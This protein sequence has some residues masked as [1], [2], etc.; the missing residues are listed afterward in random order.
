MSRF[1]RTFKARK[2]FLDELEVGSSV[3]FAARAAGGTT[4]NFKRWRKD[5]EDFARDWDEAEEAGT[6]HLEDEA[7]ARAIKKSDPLMMFMLKARRPEKFDRG[8]K[9]ELSGGIDVTGAKAKL[10]NKI[11]R[12][13]AEGKLPTGGNKEEPEILEAAPQEKQK[14]LPPPDPSVSGKRGSKRR[15]VE[16]GNRRQATS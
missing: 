2:A 5:D 16:P 13:Q 11:A 8:S 15:A 3:S 6:D 4:K 12:L 7:Y 1:V 10:L 14:L 9:L